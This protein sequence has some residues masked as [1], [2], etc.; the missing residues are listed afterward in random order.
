MEVGLGA[1]GD[2]EMDAPQVPQALRLAQAPLPH[3]QAI[4]VTIGVDVVDLGADRGEGAV[5]GVDAVV[6]MAGEVAVVD[7]EVAE[8]GVGVEVDG[9]AV[10]FDGN[11]SRSSVCK[12]C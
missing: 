1:D 10:A 11:D 12:P 2:A 7:G 4:A 8:V 5:D 3:L 9:A 6:G